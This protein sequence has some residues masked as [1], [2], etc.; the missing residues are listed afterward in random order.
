MTRKRGRGHFLSSILILTLISCTQ[1]PPEPGVIT[2]AVYTAP[3]NLDPRYGTD[4]VSSR[5][6]QLIF[7][8]LVNLD[9]K[10]LVTPGLASS[11]ETSDYR[12]YRFN[13]RQDVRFH[14]GHELTAKDVVYTYKNI[15]DPKSAS[16][17]RGAFQLVESVTAIDRSVHSRVRPEGADGFV[18]RQPGRRPDSARRRRP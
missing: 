17:W 15:L 16:P 11:W 18:S 2:V 5:A 13:L 3:N 4:S 1:A 12:T 6:H 10:M 14:D 9:D 7:N 8:N